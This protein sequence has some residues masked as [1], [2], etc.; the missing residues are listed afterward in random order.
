MSKENPYVFAKGISGLI[1]LSVNF[2]FLGLAI[3]V[4]PIWNNQPIPAALLLLAYII[5]YDVA[6]VLFHHFDVYKKHD[7]LGEWRK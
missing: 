6:R 4:I 5:W 1:M 3:V 2:I 7:Q